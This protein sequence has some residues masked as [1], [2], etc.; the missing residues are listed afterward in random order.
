[1]ARGEFAALEAMDEEFR[2][3]GPAHRAAYGN[4]GVFQRA[5]MEYFDIDC[6]GCEGWHRHEAGDGWI[7]AYPQSSGAH[8][9]YVQMLY[10]HAWTLRGYGPAATVSEYGWKHYF[11]HLDRAWSYLQDHQDVFQN[12]PRA[13]ELKLKIA[14]Q[15]NVP[16]DEYAA[17]AAAA[18]NRFPDYYD[19]HFAVSDVQSPAEMGRRRHG[20]R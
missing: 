16:D 17:M 5:V 4:S 9:S 2:T 19:L 14:H 13:A 18:L 11:D 20:H 10:K 15:L 7:K 1:M 8:L 12:V 3:S 6:F